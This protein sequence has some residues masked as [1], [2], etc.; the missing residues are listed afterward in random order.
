[1][2]PYTEYLTALFYSISFIGFLTLFV[3]DVLTI[4]KK[5]NEKRIFRQD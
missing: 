1:M 4:K 3:V 2:I 5:V